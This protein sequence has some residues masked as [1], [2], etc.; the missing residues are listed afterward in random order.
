[1]SSVECEAR[2]GGR[3]S[4]REGGGEEGRNWAAG[5]PYGETVANHSFSLLCSTGFCSLLCVLHIAWDASGTMSLLW[6][7][8]DGLGLDDRRGLFQSL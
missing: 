5:K 8:C 6:G 7:M 2:G 1:M 4:G 3:M